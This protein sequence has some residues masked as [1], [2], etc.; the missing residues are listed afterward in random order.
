MD[1]VDRTTIKK[2]NVNLL[3][4]ITLFMQKSQLNI[5]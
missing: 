3:L 1:S 4:A 2:N 5:T